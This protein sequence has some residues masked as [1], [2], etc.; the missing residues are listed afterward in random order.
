MQKDTVMF[1]FDGTV[2]DTNELILKSWKHAFR[3][4]KG[5]DV[6]DETIIATLGET[7]EHT[8]RRFF[9]GDDEAVQKNVDI[10]RRYHRDIFYDTIKL[11]PGISEML[12]ELKR[13]GYKLAMVTSRLKKTAYIGIDKYNLR[14]RFDVIVTAD[15]CEKHKP[16]PEPIYTALKK[17][18]SSPDSAVMVGDTV[19]DL[20]CADNAGVD[21]VLVNWSLALKGKTPETEPVYRVDTPADIVKL[22]KDI[23]KR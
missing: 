20:G 9:G 4:I 19:H 22:L 3:E 8:M 14:E 11:F 17:L 12:D 6:D 1:D 15:D 13:L 16:D 5:E 21:S 2:M 10:Y 23:N 7:L 18:G